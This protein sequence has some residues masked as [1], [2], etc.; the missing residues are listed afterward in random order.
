[1][2]LYLF[3][4]LKHRT[5]NNKLVQRQP[6][7]LKYQTQFWQFVPHRNMGQSMIFF[8]NIARSPLNIQGTEDTGLLRLII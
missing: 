7:D 8:F 6:T 1:M 4:V 5:L 3:H 2:N